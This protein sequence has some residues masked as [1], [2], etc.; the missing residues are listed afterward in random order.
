MPAISRE[1]RE[2]FEP[3]AVTIIGDSLDESVRAFGVV[4]DANP[5]VE[6]VAKRIVELHQHGQRDLAWLRNLALRATR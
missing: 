3:D 2:F 4:D 6:L 1:P 5:A